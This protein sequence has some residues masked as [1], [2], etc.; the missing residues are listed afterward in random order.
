M[1]SLESANGV[2]QKVGSA[3]LMARSLKVAGLILAISCTLLSSEAV[4]QIHEIQQPTSTANPANDTQPPQHL[5][6]SASQPSVKTE[7]ASPQNSG[8]A[9][10]GESAVQG[11]AGQFVFRKQVEEV[12][13]HATVVDQQNN[14]VPDLG[15]SG[16]QVYEDGKLQQITSFHQEH[17]PVALGILIDNSGSMLPKRAAVNHAALNLIHST[18]PQDEIF[19]VNFG[20]EYYL[21]QDF[22]NDENRLKAALEHIETRGSTALYDAVVASAAHMRQETNLQKRALL[23]VTDGGDNASQETLEEAVQA[24]QQKDG[25]VVYVIA[26][27]TPAKRTTSTM[28]ALEALSQ[29]TGG[30]AYF[31]TDAQEVD[32]ITRAIASAIRSQYVIGYKSSSTA[33][34]R[35]F[36]GIEVQAYDPGRRKLRVQTR[37]GYYSDSK[38]GTS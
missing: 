35:T 19:V 33:K 23:V 17:I 9:Q 4:A 26:L 10:S 37:N 3:R 28:R 25:P 20:E 16:F 30:T 18:N 22:T 21:D 11:D 12:V 24:L 5:S 7:E 34:G 31:P 36:H 29:K 14:L 15:R 1:M 27:T 38:G 8:A 32:S 13:L 6:P 2:L